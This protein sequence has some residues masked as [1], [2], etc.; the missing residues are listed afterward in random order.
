MDEQATSAEKVEGATPSPAEPN[1]GASPATPE[2]RPAAAPETGGAAAAAGNSPA[3][4]KA[5]EEGKP[6]TDLPPADQTEAVSPTKTWV[7][8]NIL[9]YVR[10]IITLSLTFAFI[11]LIVKPLFPMLNMIT[12]A[13][14]A[15]KAAGPKAGATALSADEI[16]KI[17]DPLYKYLDKILP[18]LMAV[19]GPIIGFWFGERTA[20]KMP[21]KDT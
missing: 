21:G 15:M 1:T 18:I 2:G 17:W 12:D 6:K 9:P 3:P 5:P 16:A 13:L 14:A 4:P 20:L 7:Q 19:Y 10:P 8:R 11:Y